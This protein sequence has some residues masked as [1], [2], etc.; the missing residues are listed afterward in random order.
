MKISGSSA[1][2]LEDLGKPAQA[3]KLSEETAVPDHGSEER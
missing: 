3:S 2:K 1:V